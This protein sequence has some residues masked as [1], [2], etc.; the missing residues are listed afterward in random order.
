MESFRSCRPSQQCLKIKEVIGQ[1]QTDRKGLG[2]S[3]TKWQSKAEGKDKR[4]TIINE[5]RLQEDS[6]TVD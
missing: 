6:R 2:L 3:A 4:D 1:T 5:V